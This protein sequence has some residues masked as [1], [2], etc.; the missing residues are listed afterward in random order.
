MKC[1]S[2]KKNQNPGVVGSSPTLGA[3]V[4]DAADLTVDRNLWRNQKA[5][6]VSVQSL[7]KMN[8]SKSNGEKKTKFSLSIKG[9]SAGRS[10][11]GVL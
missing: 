1:G 7:I 9:P 11:K 6:T 4:Y 3:T 2:K 5:V 10:G 8:A